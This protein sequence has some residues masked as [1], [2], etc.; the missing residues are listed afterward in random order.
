MWNGFD[1]ENMR[2]MIVVRFGTSFEE[3][4]TLD[5]KFCVIDENVKGKVK[6]S[7]SRTILIFGVDK[8]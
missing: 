8:S 7:E 2:N 4:L 6:W 3:L 1:F 5:C